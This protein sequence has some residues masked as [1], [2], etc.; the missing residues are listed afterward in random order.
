MEAAMAAAETVLDLLFVC[1]S[2]VVEDT[3]GAAVF[4]STTTGAISVVGTRVFKED[5]DDGDGVGLAVSIAVVVVVVAVGASVVGTATVVG[6][7]VETTGATVGARVSIPLNSI[8]FS[9]PKTWSNSALHSL[10]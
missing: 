2:S 7:A 5:N 10:I 4:S 9:L 3:E 8:S 1:V 6:L